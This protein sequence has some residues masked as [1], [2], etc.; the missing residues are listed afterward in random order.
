MISEQVI[1]VKQKSCSEE[2]QDTVNDGLQVEPDRPRLE[3]EAA[4]PQIGQCHQQIYYLS[5]Q[6]KVIVCCGIC[7][8]IFYR[9]YS[10]NQ[11]DIGHGG[12]VDSLAQHDQGEDENIEPFK[13]TDFFFVLTI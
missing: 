13:M 10:L 6:T 11:N 3:I 4:Q 7:N 9:Y 5:G 12:I 1:D 8:V 2:N